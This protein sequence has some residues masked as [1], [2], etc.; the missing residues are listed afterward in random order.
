MTECLFD[1]I[2]GRV[3]VRGISLISH[4]SPAPRFD[5][6]DS[7]AYPIWPTPRS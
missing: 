6:I 1:L 7:A 2:T 5:V 3:N 4:E